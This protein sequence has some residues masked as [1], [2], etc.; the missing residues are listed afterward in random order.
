MLR[1]RARPI[2]ISQ[3]L[4]LSKTRI[5][6]HALPAPLLPISLL[7]RIRHSR[8][9]RVEIRSLRLL[10]RKLLLLLHIVHATTRRPHPTHLHRHLIPHILQVLHILLIPTLL[11]LHASLVRGHLAGMRL[12]LLLLTEQHLHLRVHA[13]NHVLGDVAVVG[14]VDLLELLLVLGAHC[15]EGLLLLLV[16]GVDLVVG[17]ALGLL[18]LRHLVH[19]LRL[20]GHLGCLALLLARVAVPAAV[21]HLGCGH[22]LLH[23][24]AVLVAAVAHGHTLRLRHARFHLVQLL[25]D[26]C[27]LHALVLSRIV[28][29]VL[30]RLLP[31]RLDLG[32][33][34]SQAGDVLR[35]LER[36]GSHRGRL[37]LVRRAC[38]LLTVVL[39]CKRSALLL[40]HHDLLRSEAL[41]V[42]CHRHHGRV[43]RHA[44]GRAAWLH[45]RR[46]GDL[47]TTRHRLCH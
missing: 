12:L 14:T 31:S 38:V 47:A 5:L 28:V 19:E 4:R 41:W 16:V 27:H 9:A 17:V 42:L 44:N 36:L 40:K 32:L 1:S 7:Q 46:L 21:G 18:H 11:L 15:E 29:L 6:L 2:V 30:L 24:H 13:L 35:N 26:L 25:G 37:S 10:L 45:A 39:L 22:L 8:K 23:G 20:L 34:C 3:R 43:G 33:H